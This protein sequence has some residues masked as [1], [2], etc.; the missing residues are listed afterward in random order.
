M[1]KILVLLST[2]NGEKYVDVQIKSVLEQKDVRVNL[3]IRD[4]G[5]TDNSANIIDAINDDRIALIKDNNIGAVKSFFRLIELAPLDY[6]FYAFCDQDDF[7]E[8]DKLYSAVE[9]LEELDE[10]KP[11]LYYSGQKLADKELNV[12]SYHNLDTK[13]S[14]EACF[15][16]NQM[17]GCTAVFNQALLAQLKRVNA[18]NIVQHDNWTYK[19]CAAIGG[20]IVI[21]SQGHILYRQH[22]NNVIGLNNSIKGKLFRA[23]R[24]F[25]TTSIS[26]SAKQ[27]LETYKTE[28]SEDWK[29]FLQIICKA[30]QGNILAKLK[31]LRTNSICFNSMALRCV[32]VAKVILGK[33]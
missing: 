14:R 25:R 32:F 30:S 4:D 21:E 16:F 1:K 18:N 20:E 19:V 6:D 3:L 12:I 10:N 26:M 11:A 2:Y 15:I 17:A 24:H 28:L 9:K 5:S 13:R 8:S 7:W 33:I 22:E 23:R 27:I 29:A 31:L